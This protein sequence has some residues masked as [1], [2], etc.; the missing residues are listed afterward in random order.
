MSSKSKKG[1]NKQTDEPKWH[2][3]LSGKRNIVG[4]E[5]NTG[6]LED[7]NNFVDIPP[8]DVKADPC[9]LLANENAP[10]L[11]RDRNQGTFVKRKSITVTVA[12]DL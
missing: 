12:A 7:Y 5:D 1:I 6:L 8:F 3:V 2:I 9:I 11:H 10:Y 4:V